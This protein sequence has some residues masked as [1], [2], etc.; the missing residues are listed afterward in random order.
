MKH[1]IF[2][3]F[4]FISVFV[5]MW[6]K[7]EVKQPDTYA[8]T[9]GVEA[10]NEEKYADAL[11]WFNRELSEHPDNGYAYVYIS[12]LRYG[13]Q[14]YGKALSAVDNALKRLPKKDKEW[15][16]LT[17]ASRAEVYTAMGD[18]IKAM[19]DLSEAIQID[20][21]NARFYNTRAQLNYELKN[22]ALADADY[23]KMI[24]MD[25]GD[26][27]GYM[28]IGRNAN[29]QE[30]WDEAVNQFNHVIK[31]AADYS[32]GYSFRADAYIGQEKWSEAT[33]DLVKALDIDGDNKAFYLMQR[34]PLEASNM[35]K[36]KLKIQMT[37]QPT[38][39]YWPYCLAVIADANNEYNEAISFY[40]KA[41]NLDANSLFLENISKCYVYQRDYAK[42]LDF[43]DRALAMAPDDYDV[44][45]LKADILSRMGKYDDCIIE[46]DKYVAKYPEYPVAYLSR[47]DDLLSARRFNDAIEDYN[48]AIVLAPSLA[49]YPYLLMRRGDA[50][51]L[52]GQTD[53]ANRDYELLLNVEK[54]SVLTSE[55]WTPFA[56]SGLGNSDKAIKTIQ[57]IIANDTTD[58]SGN[59][60]N[61]ACV[62]ARLGKTSEAIQYLKD[63]IEKGYRNFSHIETD[64]DLDCIRELPEYQNIV[65]QND[66]EVVL[67]EIK[68]QDE[69]VEYQTE[70]V[71]VPFTKE[72]G[73]T[74]VKCNIN[75]L[76]LH[77]V[78]DTGAA[79]VTMSMVE[80][81]FML[82][83]DYIKPSDIVG[84]ARYMDANGDIT[85]GTVVNL[86]NV[87]F[88]GLELDNVR[89]S[90]VRN[91]KAPLLLGQ[92]VLG[93]LGKIEIDNPGMKLVITHKVS[94]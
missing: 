75:G 8:Y 45:D 78:F 72:G 28:G 43:A 29:A 90:V 47:A 55:S 23:Q 87:N 50:F 2:I 74:K 37:K 58:I 53:N 33:D 92:S 6:A 16:S 52:T 86:R 70:I 57:F 62:Y 59:L 31:L 49:E 51:R 61:A 35:L 81:N 63:A 36:S 7:P 60:Y 14:E 54:D 42:A 22:Y 80:A 17:F 73:V 88:G 89:A 91:Q 46:R 27:M 15:R 82:K 20:P 3:V 5:Q 83:N 32:S 1:R 67:E 40:E 68:S 21:T 4:T 18:T 34:L 93:R 85:E 38:N 65:D 25:Q 71:E 77:F 30:R 76:P 26:V 10:Y 66:S 13:N 41:N 48:T 56:Y 39:R 12:I 44:V 24:N 19:K 11:D 79:D 84:S 64:Y 9:R 94:K 69:L